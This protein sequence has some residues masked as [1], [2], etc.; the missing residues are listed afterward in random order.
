[1]QRG[2][3]STE[4]RSAFS[5]APIVTGKEWM[6]VG[7]RNDLCPEGNCYL[8]IKLL[9]RLGTDAYAGVKTDALVLSVPRD[10]FLGMGPSAESACVLRRLRP[11]GVRGWCAAR[12]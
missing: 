12:S 2:S 11:G 3:H 7:G 4:G 8:R 9:E 10:C 5:K 1:M 6:A